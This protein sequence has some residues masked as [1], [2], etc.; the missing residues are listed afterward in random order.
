MTTPPAYLPPNL[1]P[2]QFVHLKQNEGIFKAHK[3][4]DIIEYFNNLIHNPRFA[5]DLYERVCEDLGLVPVASV[6]A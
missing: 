6:R 4:D 1:T 2:A 5:D 3:G